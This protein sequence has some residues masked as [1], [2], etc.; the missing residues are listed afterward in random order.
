MGGQFMMAT[1]ALFKELVSE[2]CSF[3]R[4]EL[5]HRHRALLYAVFTVL[6]SATV[7]ELYSISLQ[8][9]NEL[10]L[11]SEVDEFAQNAKIQATC[12]L[13]LCDSVCLWK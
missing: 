2:I 1:A 11:F 7:I 3:H 9:L 6:S 8:L 12:A 4:I 10:F 5:C 13:H